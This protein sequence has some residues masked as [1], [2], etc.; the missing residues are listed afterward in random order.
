MKFKQNMHFSEINIDMSEE[1]NRPIGET[2]RKNG[3]YWR[4]F[5]K[6]INEC[7]NDFKPPHS[8]DADEEEAYHIE[9]EN[10]L[11][12]LELREQIIITKD[13]LPNYFS[14]KIRDW[15]YLLKFA[16]IMSEAK[17]EYEVE[18][19]FSYKLIDDN[20]IELNLGL[21]PNDLEN[22]D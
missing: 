16:K 19:P 14:G 21:I 3:R 20:A 13:T 4:L 10:K 18:M 12:S 22:E 2:G 17:F 6:D 9:R 5:L 15:D 11:R 7:N 1:Y 8:K